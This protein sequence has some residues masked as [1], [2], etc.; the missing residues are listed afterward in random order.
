M[1]RG[2]INTLRITCFIALCVNANAQPSSYFTDHLSHLGFSF[3][4]DSIQPDLEYG[5]QYQSNGDTSNAILCFSRVI[6]SS[7]H[8]SLHAFILR[9]LL[10][11]EIRDYSRSLQDWTA[12][13]SLNPVDTAIFYYR[14]LC[15]LNLSAYQESDDDFTNFIR[16]NPLSA[17]AYYYRGVCQEKEGNVENALRDYSQAI[18]INNTASDFYFARGKLRATRAEQNPQDAMLD[19]FSA[20][21]MGN[22]KAGQLLSEYSKK[23]NFALIIDSLRTFVV[24]EIV[25]EATREEIVKNIKES[26]KIIDQGKTTLIYLTSP[27]VRKSNNVP[28]SI[29]AVLERSEINCNEALLQ[30]QRTTSLN[31]RC[32]ALILKKKATVINDPA[33]L[34]IANNIE[35]VADD[36]TERFNELKNAGQQTNDWEMSLLQTRLETQFEAYQSRLETLKKEKNIN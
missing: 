34:A 12:A 28:T 24:Q 4:S 7:K 19:L 17:R 27:V 9:A 20:L 6:T 35:T 2:I 32:L 18:E 13:A 23:P 33:L 30:T 36:F 15:L 29:S 26:K 14:G 3:K 11:F 16:A 31:M 25:V 22:S 8:Q 21:K 1:I 10:R 5:F